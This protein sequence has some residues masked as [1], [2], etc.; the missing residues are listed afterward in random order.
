MSVEDAN[1]SLRSNSDFELIG[2][3]RDIGMC[4]AS[5]ITG[6]ALDRA[7]PRHARLLEERQRNL[8]KVQNMCL[9][10][11]LMEKRRSQRRNATTATSNESSLGL[12]SP[13]VGVSSVFPQF[14]CLSSST[15]EDLENLTKIWVG[16]MQEYQN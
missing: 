5:V 12:S 9:P 6:C 8:S 16:R 10:D 14:V 7:G 11:F 2:E 15:N 4:D 3:S 13:D 1:D